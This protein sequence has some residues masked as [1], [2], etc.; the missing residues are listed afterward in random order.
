MRN[1]PLPKQK[2][3]PKKLQSSSRKYPKLPHPS[4]SPLFFSTRTL[5]L[6]NPHLLAL[7]RTNQASLSPLAFHSEQN[8][9]FL[10]FSFKLFPAGGGS[11][12]SRISRK[13][14]KRGTTMGIGGTSTRSVT[15]TSSNISFFQ[16]FLCFLLLDSSG[17]GCFI[18]QSPN[19]NM[20]SLRSDK[21]PSLSSQKICKCVSES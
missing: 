15:G 14:R 4:Q 8:G 17:S 11:P 7:Q 10:E 12:R 20:I 19:A 2:D 1:L 9:N 18:Q 21:S 5:A 13:M 16:C 3:L 6:H